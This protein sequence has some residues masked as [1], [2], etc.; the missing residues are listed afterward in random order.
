MTAPHR[1]SGSGTN[2]APGV[3][4]RGVQIPLSRPPY[5]H[6]FLSRMLAGA[7]VTHLVAPRVYD[8]V[9]PAW[10]PGPPR[11]WT[12]SSGLAELAVA[13]LLAHPRTRRLGG[14]AA[15]A[16]FVAVFP[17]NLD[18]A[19]QRRHQPG[20]LVACLARL[21]LQAPL[22]AWAVRVGRG[23]GAARSGTDQP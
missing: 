16:L 23:A 5:G 20:P 14:W 10:V 2:R 4:S 17:A 3:A 12:V 11:F 1:I 22:V 8:G 21:P 7:G 9:V 15:A 13:G 18:M 6:V 19:W